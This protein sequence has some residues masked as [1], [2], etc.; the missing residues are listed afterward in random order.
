MEVQL[1]ETDHDSNRVRQIAQPIIVDLED[2]ECLKPMKVFRETIYI[3]VGQ[4][5]LL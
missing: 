3:I 2:F 5:K 4:H 1:A